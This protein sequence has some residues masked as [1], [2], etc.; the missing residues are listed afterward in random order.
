MHRFPPIYG[1]YSKPLR[2]API[3]TE[4]TSP[5]NRVNEKRFSVLELFSP[6]VRI[7]L[8]PTHGHFALLFQHPL[9]FNLRNENREIFTPEKEFVSFLS[10]EMDS[11]TSAETSDSSLPT[12]EV[13]GAS[14]TEVSAM[15]QETMIAPPPYSE[16][17]ISAGHEL[18][19]SGE[20]RA[21]KGLNVASN[22]F[23]P[24]TLLQE[25]LNAQGEAFLPAGWSF[26]VYD[27]E[28]QH[29]YTIPN[30]SV[31][32]TSGSLKYCTYHEIYGHGTRFR[33]QLCNKFVEGR[34]SAGKKCNF[35]HAL[36]DTTS[37]ANSV[38]VNENLSDC[39][40]A[41]DVV[42]SQHRPLQNTH[43]YHTL[44]DNL[45]IAVHAPNAHDELPQLIFSCNLLVTKGSLQA[46][47]Q[48]VA[49]VRK[50]G[51]RGGSNAGAGSGASNATASHN[52]PR[53]CAHFQFRKMCNLGEE[54][55]FIHSLAPYVQPKYR[56]QGDGPMP[57]HTSAPSSTQPTQQQ[58]VKPQQSMPSVQVGMSSGGLP[59]AAGGE[60]LLP[61]APYSTKAPTPV[62]VVGRQ[63][64]A[65][66]Q[67]QVPPRV[68]QPQTPIHGLPTFIP[69][70]GQWPILFAPGPQMVPTAG[71]MVG[72]PNP[73]V[74]QNRNFPVFILQGPPTGGMPP[75]QFMFNGEGIPVL[76]PY[77]QSVPAQP[78]A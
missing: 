71:S 73:S 76:V 25:L 6:P 49:Q 21:R 15:H 19:S 42:N 29:H 53:H 57:P 35:I 1:Y 18:P 43:G 61:S 40:T 22:D 50:A 52:R 7:P 65:P 44:S 64:Q 41:Q 37:S 20:K 11:I 39:N 32:A 26:S 46:F 75:G 27:T 23:P 58:P 17:V 70:G 24:S 12:T 69:A 62:V 34:C 63:P 38:H 78:T 47:E 9:S 28:L 45:L 3:E 30:Q 14:L 16:Q 51:Q 4:R 54:C 68:Y 8:I 67:Q 36:Y 60:V 2:C 77:Q 72:A 56:R 66:P 5:G 48:V 55:H 74:D 33:F 31:T 10:S 59:H 13:H